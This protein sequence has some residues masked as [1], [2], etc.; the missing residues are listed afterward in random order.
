MGCRIDRARDWTLRITHESKLRQP[1]WFATLTYDNEHLP[2]PPSL[3]YPDF[4]G[5]MKRVRRRLGP[6]RFFMCGEYGEQT[7]RPHYH[8]ILFGLE[9]K[10]LKRWGGTDT[11]PTWTSDVL[12]KS[13]GKGMIVLGQVTTQSA[14]YVARYNLK[15]INGDRAEA[16]YRWADPETGEQHQLRP[17]F[18]QMSRK[19]G[20]GAEW[21]DKYH[22]D[23][24]THDYAV[25]D[26][27]KLPIPKYYDKRATDKGYEL[28]VI[29][30]ARETR[31]LPK[32]WNN[33]VERLAT[34]ETVLKSKLSTSK[35]GL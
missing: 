27:A 29:K 26:G 9:L 11:M 16:H 35:R 6:F 14:N 8:A 28:D 32:A 19:P 4:Q 15:K 22:S 13:W 34:R 25:S 23:F 21:Y 10:D 20:I 18:C 2:N 12:T 3:N 31:A 17:E 33:T 24:H 5:W 1:N 7:R 30:M